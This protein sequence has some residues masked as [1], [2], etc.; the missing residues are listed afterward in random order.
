MGTF[1]ET[2]I[3][4]YRLSFPDQGKQTSIFQIYLQ[5]TNGSLP[6]PFL[7]VANKEKFPFS[8]SSVFCIN[9]YIYICVCVCV[10]V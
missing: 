8:V 6:F 5:G 4:D 7:F 10:C 9:I 2:A 1:V 3:V